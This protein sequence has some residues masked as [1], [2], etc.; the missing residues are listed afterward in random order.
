MT[1]SWNGAQRRWNLSAF[2]IFGEIF[3]KNH[4]CVGKH[5]T[6]NILRASANEN[7]KQQIETLITTRPPLYHAILPG[8]LQVAS[9]G[10]LLR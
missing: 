6:C 10:F 9:S 8:P 5:T 2:G 4:I 7:D 3:A 1:G